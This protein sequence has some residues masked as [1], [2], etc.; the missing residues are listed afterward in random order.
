MLVSTPISTYI[1]LLTL[2][3]VLVLLGVRYEFKPL[4]LA[5]Q[6]PRVSPAEA[7][8]TLGLTPPHPLGLTP[9]PPPGD[10]GTMAPPLVSRKLQ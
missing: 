9:H 8:P 2:P 10:G 3:P 1:S 4:E 6:K 7:Y 5:L